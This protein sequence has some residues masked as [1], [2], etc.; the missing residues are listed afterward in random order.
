MFNRGSSVARLRH[1]H[2]ND[3]VMEA[4]STTPPPYTRHEIF[5]IVAPP[6]KRTV[7]SKNPTK[8]EP[9]NIIMKPGLN[10]EGTMKKLF[11]SA[12]SP[13]EFES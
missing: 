3:V 4:A 10:F 9:G 8:K 5:E 2:G 11:Y 1:D 13:S 7:K 12:A 6:I